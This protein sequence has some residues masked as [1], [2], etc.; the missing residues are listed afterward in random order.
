MIRPVIFRLAAEH[1][2]LEAER[3]FEEHQSDLGRRFRSSVDQTIERMREF[4]LSFPVV[5]GQKRRA[6]I[7]R[8]PY[9]IG[10]AH[11]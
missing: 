3:W 9:E 7:P 5:H 10:R 1:E 8:F 2:M 6:L 11:V 4:P